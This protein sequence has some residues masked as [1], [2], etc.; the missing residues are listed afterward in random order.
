M[1]RLFPTLVPPQAWEDARISDKSGVKLD[2]VDLE[3]GILALIEYLTEVSLM[4]AFRVVYY[5]KIV[6]EIN[7]TLFDKYKAYY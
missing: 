5:I 6:T 7:A 2:D 4:C 1:I 3:S